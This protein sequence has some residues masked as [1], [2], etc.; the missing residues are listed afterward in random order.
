MLTVW[1]TVGGGAAADVDDD[2]ERAEDAA[3]AL[4]GAVLAPAD[5]RQGQSR[6]ALLPKPHPPSRTWRLNARPSTHNTA[7]SHAEPIRRR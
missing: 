7:L 4:D 5:A 6:L 3:G 2:P 1:W